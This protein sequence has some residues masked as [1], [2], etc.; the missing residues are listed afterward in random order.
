MVVKEWSNVYSRLCPFQLLS[1]LEG[2][3][4]HVVAWATDFS[5]HAD[6]HLVCV[7][8]EASGVYSS[9]TVN[10][11]GRTRKSTSITNAI[12]LQIVPSKLR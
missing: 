1:I 8:E 12:Y 10:I 2:T 3:Q 4:Q 9:Q 7:Q 5:A 11:E 6:S